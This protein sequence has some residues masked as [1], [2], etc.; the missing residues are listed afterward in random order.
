[1]PPFIPRKRLRPLTPEAGPSTSSNSHPARNDKSKSVTIPPRKRTLADELDAGTGPKRTA[2]QSKALLEKL[3]SGDDDDE[4]SLSSFSDDDFEDVPRAKRQKVQDDSDDDVEFEDVQLENF[5]TSAVPGPSGP[6]PSGDLE[7]TLKR[8]PRISLTNPHGTKKGPSKI[9]REIRISTHQLHVQCLMLHNSIRN[10]WLCDTE[11]QETLVKQLPAS[12]M[13]AVGQWRLDSGLLQKEPDNPKRRRKGKEKDVKDKKSDAR[14]Q[15]DWGEPAERLESG[16]VNM[17]GGDPILR[18]MRL[19]MIHW[20]QRF[21]ITAPGSRKVGYMSLERLDEEMKIFRRAHDPELHGERIRDI[22][23]FRKCAEALEGSRDVGAQLFTALLRGLGIETRMVANLQPLGFGWSQNEEASEKNPRRLKEKKPIVD[24]EDFSEDDN[25]DKEE[26]EPPKTAKSKR[27]A[28]PRSKPPTNSAKI[29]KSVSSRS[30]LQDAPIELSDSELSEPPSEDD[31]DSVIDVTPARQRAQWA[32]SKPY[33]KDLTFPHY[34]T[35]VL[36]PVTNKYTAVDAIVLHI[37]ASK[38][39]L[40]EKFEPRGA[41][42]DK[43]KQVTSY[44]VGYSPDGT[45][46]DVT[47]RYLKRHVWPGRTKGNRIPSAKQPHYYYWRNDIVL[48]DDWFKHVMSHYVRGTQ[49]CPRSEIDDL[50]EATDLNPAKPEKKEIPAGKETLQWYKSSAEF[51][52]E[53]HLKREEAPTA[54]HVKM[55]TVKGKGQET[56]EEKVYLRKDVVNCK[57]EETWHKEGRVPKYGEEPLKRVPYRAATTNRRR[58][59]AEA[60]HATGEKM[61]QG[62]YSLHQTEWIIPSPI[63]NG[64]IPK[65]RFGN[66][67]LYVDSML[68]EGGAHIPR[69]GTVKICK[70]LGI[71]YAEAVIGFDFGNRMAVPVIDGVVVAIEHA[72][73]VMEEWVKDE[74]ERTRKED[75]KRTKAA[76]SMWRKMLMGMRL[77]KRLREDYGDDA[78]DQADEINPWTNRKGKEVDKDVEAQRRIM[79]QRGDD[80]AGGFNPES[81]NEEDVDAH[82]AQS[83]FPVHHEDGEHEGGGFMVEDHN[84]IPTP[85]SARPNS[86]VAQAYP[87]PQSLLSNSITKSV[88]ELEDNAMAIESETEVVPVPKQRGRPSGSASK[89]HTSILQSAKKSKA[90]PKD[91]SAQKKTPAPQSNG[92]RKRQVT[93][94]EVDDE[95]S[96]LYESEETPKK[97]ANRGGGRRATMAAKTTASLRKAPK[98]NAARKSETALKSHYFEQNDEDDDE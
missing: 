17:S 92:K 54:K 31:D 15:R 40:V 73:K 97:I 75:E 88:Q 83:Y 28:V 20:K 56:L 66:I 50:E 34:W 84:D 29:T 53:R 64:I 71:D 81:D 6:A 7:L 63:E 51:V 59:L 48:Y 38:P 47:T 58:E 85:P 68:P 76:I 87:T 78:E 94:S 55:F 35:E 70:R 52:L 11:V 1:M 4:S 32:P 89:S 57:T 49:K 25:S 8:D 23:E 19:L 90:P 41:K 2:E 82:H 24:D 98:R 16:Q 61:L 3:A 44:I 96:G 13:Q 65:N 91:P 69:R 5:Q 39:E 27:K 93:D 45:A 18:L 67:D 77:V 12:I 46:K 22:N 36:S 42:A 21:R 37:I 14:S 79:E 95:E 60:E 43:A 9:E 26:P 62:L 30:G 72:P 74:A 80:M 86:T 33:D 10:E